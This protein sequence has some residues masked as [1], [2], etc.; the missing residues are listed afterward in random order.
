MKKILLSTAFVICGGLQASPELVAKLKADLAKCENEK[1]QQLWQT[2][3]TIR[4]G[5]DIVDQVFAPEVKH[6]TAEAK[7]P[8]VAKEARKTSW[9]KRI[10]AVT[11]TAAVVAIAAL[12]LCKVQK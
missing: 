3:A 7:K 1:S 10:A 5:H 4:H 9:A 11:G 12:Q 8:V 2:I 6:V